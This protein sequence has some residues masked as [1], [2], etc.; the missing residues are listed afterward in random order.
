MSR[1]TLPS[2]QIASAVGIKPVRGACQESGVS[3]L[4]S[5]LGTNKA[6]KPRF[7]PSLSG[8]SP[9]TLVSFTPKGDADRHGRGHHACQGGYSQWRDTTLIRTVPP[10]GTYRRP[11]PRV[12]G[13]SKGG[14]RFLMGEVPLYSKDIRRETSGT[15]KKNRRPAIDNSW[16]YPTNS[17]P[18]IISVKARYPVQIDRPSTSK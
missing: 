7:C 11:M 17:G 9:Q 10:L 6:F 2:I 12:L 1:H 13:G 15:P 3:L 16:L 5:R 4:S 14:G 18:V 8:K